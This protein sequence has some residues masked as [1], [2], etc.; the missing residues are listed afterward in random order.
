MSNSPSD[1]NG[2]TRAHR[3]RPCRRPFWTLLLGILCLG[4]SHAF[5]QTSQAIVVDGDG[6]WRDARWIYT[7]GQFTSLLQEAGYTVTT[8]SPAE[9]T[10]AT[11]SGDALLAVPSLETLPFEAMAALARIGDL[12][13]SLM[14]SGGEP[15]R[16]PLYLA[17][18]GA[19]VD[20]AAYEAATGSPAPRLGTFF[21]VPTLSPA[22]QQYTTSSGERVPIVN[23]RGLFGRFGSRTRVIGDVL[24]PAATIYSDLYPSFL[25]RPAMRFLIVWLP[26]PHLSEPYR[27][28]FVA[29]LRGAATGVHLQVAGPAV[30]MWLPGETVTG[31]ATVSNTSDTPM[32]ATLEWSISGGAGPMPQSPISVSIAAEQNGT[33]ALS[34]PSLPGGDYTLSF[35]LMV[36]GQQ[37][38]TVDTSLRIF[39]PVAS[40]QPDQ[41]IKVIDGSFYANGERVFLHGVNYWPRYTNPLGAYANWLDPEGY[42]PVQIEADLSL[43][44]SLNFNLVNIRYI[45]FY[46]GPPRNLASLA[47]ALMDFLDRCRN[48]GI[49]VRI[50][51]PA[52]LANNAFRGTLTPALSSFVNEAYL[53]G[54][55]RVFAYDL[56]W[57]PFLGMQKS[58][59]YNGYLNGEPIRQG[60]GRSALDGEW[61]VWV[62]D[63]YGSLANAEQIWEVD[64]PLDENGQLTNP[65]D[66][67]MATDGPWRVMVAAYRRFADDYLGR[68]LGLVAREIRRTDP[69]TLVTYRNWSAMTAAGN[70]GMGYDLG[71]G[72]AHID[73]LSPES[74]D[75]AP[76]PERR[77]RGFATA[78]SRYRSGGKPVQ[79]V[80][81][82]YD[83]GANGDAAARAA[84][85][86]YC[87]DFMRLVAEDGSNADTV[88]WWPG[89]VSLLYGT[90]LGIIDPDGTPRGC[91]QVLAKY[92]AQFRETPPDPGPASVTLKIDRDADA[93]GQFGLFLNWADQYAAAKAAG[94]AVQLTGEGTGTDTSTMPL[95]QVGNV[96]YAGAGPLKFA[97]A[98]FG[99]LRVVC[100]GVDTTVENGA[101]VPVPAGA[102]CQV[103]A[104]L[105]NT[106]EAQWL[107]AAAVRGGVVLHTTAGDVPLS[108]PLPSL[109]R[110]ALAPLNV[111]M[112]QST[113]L[114]TGR[115]RAAGIGDFGEVL[116]LTLA[117]NSGT[118][119]P[120]AV[121]LAP[122]ENISAPAAGVT[123]TV[124]ITTGADCAWSATSTEPWVTFVPDTGTGSGQLT[125]I[126]Q[127]NAGPARQTAVT[128]A[129]HPLTVLQA[130]ATQSFVSPPS[131][132]PESL[133]FGSL[134]LGTASSTQT[135]TLTNTAPSPLTLGLIA[136]GGAD[137]AD[138]IQS[139]TCGS[140]VGP[141]TSCSITV[142]FTPSETGSRTASLFISANT[143]SGALRVGLAGVGVGTGPVPVIQGIADVWTYTPGI[144]P[145]LWVA[146]GGSSL[147]P[148]PQI[149]DL[150]AR[151][152]LSTNL[153]GVEVTF[154]GV[155]AVLAYAGPSQ[156]NALVPASLQPGQVQVVVNVDG[157]AS[158]A[159]LVTAKRTQPAIYALPN[160]DGTAFSVTAALQGTGF[161]VG[162]PAIDPRVNRAVFPGDI[163]DLYMIGLGATEDPSAF[164]TGRQFAGA[165]PIR[166]PIAARV[167]GQPATVI[168]AGL[169][170]PGLYLVR[171][172]IPAPL[173][174]GNQPIEVA[175]GTPP[176]EETKTS[177]LLSLTIAEP[178]A[179]LIPNG[180]FESALAKP[181][182]FETVGA[183]ATLQ[184]TA[185]TS[186]AGASSA[187][188][189][190][191]S[192]APPSTVRLSLSGLTLQA[193]RV[194]RLMFSAKAETPRSM[195]LDVTGA[196]TGEALWDTSV[197][198]PNLWQRY[199]LY[200]QTAAAIPTAQLDF[201]FGDRTGN[202]WLDDV[203]LEGPAP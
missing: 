24:A 18:N 156:I 129:G 100:P 53:P 54:N 111:T 126:I 164:V 33:M 57:E 63:Q 3:V 99:G 90:D 119:G 65:T 93:R 77:K 117:V 187:A 76:W 88:W 177:R 169:T 115:M 163:I 96:P 91:A 194:Y 39:D 67:Q 127:P 51:L 69:D 46:V 36:G 151:E 173:E 149:A 73:F 130:G 199:V 184:T 121:S 155:P 105:V 193:G 94:Q 136:I 160:A 166:A 75:P 25:G 16:N 59:G 108:S 153:G 202:L 140:S 41:K 109:Q 49:W 98:E 12:G 172:Q 70:A 191:T 71:T 6:P 66:D 21:A 103:T 143:G 132:S 152:E 145:G 147:S 179:N 110:A 146:I 30:P 101:Q 142:R 188:I 26:T 186:T 133:N 158:N 125:Y 197:P 74:Y 78:Y 5:A 150:G 139:N 134:T 44:E 170:S 35:H 171:I 113:L 131:L 182:K 138:F 120:C 123:A 201:S 116:R 124:S 52:T 20:A 10:Y 80:E 50:D 192:T 174:P 165:F 95:I 40:R 9:I 43:L 48:H 190:V 122:A 7:A 81:F 137:S 37:V 60:E 181:W 2:D 198:V 62:D 157:V 31:E 19:W 141:G 128:I 196:A 22:D 58:G 89:G 144:A 28:Q 106:G 29:A 61:R 195:H 167:G 154:N 176:G 23:R 72:A 114:L 83:I 27:A 92:G 148:F 87:E 38:D 4:L 17:P 13:G 11:V 68:N 102:D 135:V 178:A 45:G 159:F 161:L 15:F 162:N 97:N 42:D 189:T 180:S 79:W 185:E 47:R 112:D 8:I 104:T 168:F 183:A 107:P 14:A 34:F 86:S 56:L 200:F 175:L 203:V 64:P 82:G 118:T 85:T 55:D 84:Q 32:D 1:P